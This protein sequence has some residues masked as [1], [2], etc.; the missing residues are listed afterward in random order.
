MSRRVR[1]ARLETRAARS[2]LSPRG[3]PYYRSVGPDIH[4]GYRKGAD[5]RRWVARTYIGNGAYSMKVIGDADD[6]MDADGETILTFDQAQEKARALVAKQLI[7]PY[8]VGQAIDDYVHHIEDRATCREVATRLGAHVPAAMKGKPVDVLT[9]QEI[10]AWHRGLAKTPPRARTKAGEGQAYRSVNMDDPETIRRRKV[11]AN[12]VMNKLKAALNHAF[13]EEKVAS[14]KAWARVKPFDKVAQPRTRYLTV[15]EA[16]RLIN[17]SDPDFR[18]LVQAALITGGRYQ[19]LARLTVADFN[20]DSGTLHIQLSKTGS[21]HVILSEE[22]SAFFKSLTASR[23]GDQPMLGRVWGRSDQTRPMKDACRK[24]KIIPEVSIHTL[25]HTWASLSV[26]GGMP[27]MVVARNLGHVD[28]RM[29]EKV[30]GH[31]SASYVAEQVRQHAPTFGIKAGN[32][33][34]IR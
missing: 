19:E 31:L 1:D 10:S 29:V 6:L 8:T 20:P 23:R 21:R 9:K 15:A 11:T 7:G 12:A 34:A 28:T 18:K 22:G 30:Y 25:R 13:K 17:A 27:L 24:A 26:M 33:K 14:N 32:V 5:A 4:V 2:K 3:K 16:Q